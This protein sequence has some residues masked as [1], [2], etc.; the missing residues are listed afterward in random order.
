MF[1]YLY[2]KSTVQ[3]RF[4]LCACLS[5]PHRK[6]QLIYL[7]FNRN[8][9]EIWEINSIISGLIW[10][11]HMRNIE[12]LSF[13]SYDNLFLKFRIRV[14]LPLFNMIISIKRFNNP[15]YINNHSSFFISM[16]IYIGGHIFFDYSV[17]NLFI[18]L[19]QRL[20]SLIILQRGILVRTIQIHIILFQNDVSIYGRIRIQS[21]YYK[22]MLCI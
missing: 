10:L 20:I 3:S 17:L 4:N 1:K 16:Q 5:V 12:Y 13:F 8:V 9:C 11:I 19:I 7:K 6:E 22:N 14:I 18:Y 2:S 15:N 21:K